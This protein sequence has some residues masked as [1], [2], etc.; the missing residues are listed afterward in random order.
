[1]YS[2]LIKGDQKPGRYYASFL[3]TTTTT[4]NFYL[5]TAQVA[6]V[7]IVAAAGTTWL[8]FFW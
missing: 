7:G 3:T 4:I 2:R 8:L 1:M 6:T 5:Y